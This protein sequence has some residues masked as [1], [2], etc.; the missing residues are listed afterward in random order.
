MTA[1]ERDL[2]ADEGVDEGSADATA[3]SGGSGDDGAGE[4]GA[5]SAASQDG[6]P[7]DEYDPTPPLDLAG[8]ARTS[9]ED[10]GPGQ[11]QQV[12]EG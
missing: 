12:G 5:L 8:A 2:T 11:Q 9:R 3:E 10:A 6:R 4:T 1:S 7:T